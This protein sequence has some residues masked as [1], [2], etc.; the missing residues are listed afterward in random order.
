[1]TKCHSLD[2]PKNNW[3]YCPSLPA[4]VVFAVLFAGTSIMHIYQA[5]KYRNNYAWTVIMGAIWETASFTIRSISTQHPTT[6]ALYDPHFLLFLIAPLWI[7]AFVYMLLGRMVYFFLADQRLFKIRAQRMTL[8]FVALDIVSFLVQI[9]G[10]VMTIS[11]N[12]TILQRGL[13]IYT[14]GV[15]MQEFFIFCFIFLVIAFQRRLNREEANRVRITQAKRLVL[16]M[17]LA[18][19]LISV[20]IFFRIIEFSAGVGTK[21]T[22]EVRDKEVY[23][24][25]FDALLM[26]F[27]LVIFNVLHPGKILAGDD[28]K[29]QKKSKT[30]KQDEKQQRK[31]ERA[32]RKALRSNE[33]EWTA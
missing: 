15:A 14:A 11:K 16:A 20:R 25:V 10:G 30:Q 17:Y 33:A 6:E 19:A 5:H 31:Q 4:A 13:N 23:Q 3:A 26:F 18:L 24:Y 32:E 8:T 29:F 12:R 7:N 27:A 28:S 22:T 2:D 21:L 9:L 1:M